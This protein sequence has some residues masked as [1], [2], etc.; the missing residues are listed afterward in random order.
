[1]QFLKYKIDFY[2]LVNK[3]GFIGFINN[4]EKVN[5]KTLVNRS[6]MDAMWIYCLEKLLSWTCSLVNPLLSIELVLSVV[7]V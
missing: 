6:T 3:V 2:V 4:V 1:M 5:P 7:S